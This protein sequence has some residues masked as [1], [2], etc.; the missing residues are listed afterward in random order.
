MLDVFKVPEEG[1]FASGLMSCSLVAT[2]AGECAAGRCD[3][4]RMCW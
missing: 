1:R 4:E 2:Q 3:A